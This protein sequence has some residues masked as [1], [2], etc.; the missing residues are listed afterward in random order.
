[1]R[2]SVG[3]FQSRLIILYL[4]PLT[5]SVWQVC[6]KT[7]LS[8]SVMSFSRP[9]VFSRAGVDMTADRTYDRVWDGLE[10]QMRGKFAC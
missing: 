1:M 4:C 9:D 5:I 10:V 3:L 2:E 7:Y 6:E 8:T